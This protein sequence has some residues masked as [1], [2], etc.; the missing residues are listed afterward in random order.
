[1]RIYDLGV[2]GKSFQKWA[3]LGLQAVGSKCLVKE[4]PVG[5]SK[6]NAYEDTVYPP[7][8]NLIQ[9]GG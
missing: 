5:S 6:V 4:V 9:V 2:I 8:H 3:D 7:T 1:M